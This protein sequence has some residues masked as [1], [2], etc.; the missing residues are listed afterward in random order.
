M[1]IR[2]IFDDIKSKLEALTNDSGR[3]VFG[4]VDLNRGQ[5]TQIKG[6]ESTGQIITFP[7]IF[8]KPEELKQV[9]RPQ[10]IYV[11]EMRIRVHVVTNNLVHLD[12]LEIFDL[13]ELVD[14]TMLDSKWDTTN[15]VSIVKG[16]DVMPETFDNNQVYELNYWVKFWNVNAYTYRDFVDANDI[17]INPD[18]PIELGLGGHIDD[19]DGEFPYPI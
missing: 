13:P 18:A 9:P 19:G 4:T 14:R 2:V 1:G 17:E 11:T 5:M 12:P 16:F 3:K 10:N 15:L 7:A 8:Y 6:F